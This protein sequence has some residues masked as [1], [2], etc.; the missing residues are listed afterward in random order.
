[1]ALRFFHGGPLTVFLGSHTQ[2]GS[3]ARLEGA[4]ERLEHQ[5]WPQVVALLLSEGGTRP[6]PGSRPPSGPVAGLQLLQAW[7]GQVRYWVRGPV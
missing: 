7:T 6:R 2:S 3:L 1:M 4:P 5:Q